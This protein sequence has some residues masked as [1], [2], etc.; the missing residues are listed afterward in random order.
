[1]NYIK[2]DSWEIWIDAYSLNHRRSKTFQIVWNFAAST[3]CRTL[4]YTMIKKKYLSKSKSAFQ[5]NIFETVEETILNGPLKRFC[6]SHLKHRRKDFH[7]K[8][9]SDSLVIIWLIFLINV[10]DVVVDTLTISLLVL[11][12]LPLL[13]LLFKIWSHWLIEYYWILLNT[14]YFQPSRY[15]IQWLFFHWPNPS[16]T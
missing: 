16:H 13:D 2:D 10:S 6:S 15:G 5:T 7:V 4:L 3:N 9:N 8:L 1:M 12:A 11:P 14:S